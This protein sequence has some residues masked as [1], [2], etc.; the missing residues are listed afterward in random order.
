MS[1]YVYFEIGCLNYK[2]KKTMNLFSNFTESLPQVSWRRVFEH[3]GRLRGFLIR[4]Y[5]AATGYLTL[6]G[7]VCSLVIARRVTELIRKSG[8]L[9]T[10]QYLKQCAVHLQQYYAGSVITVGKSAVNVSLSRA[11]IPTI[12]PKHHR[13]I[14]MKRGDRGN[15]LVKVS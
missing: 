15:R 9:F 12:I 6:E 8:L 5:L 10:S 7:A 11:G 2:L 3:T 13:F 14:I 1:I 4:I